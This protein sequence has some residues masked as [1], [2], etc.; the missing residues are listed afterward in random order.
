[1][2]R[3]STGRYRER[4]S[5]LKYAVVIMEGAADDPCEELGNRTPLEA[6]ETP[7]LDSLVAKGRIG[8]VCLVPPDLD[9]DDGVA[10]ASLLGIAP[11]RIAPCG[12]GG[13]EAA[14]AEID[15]GDAAVLRLDLL[16][17]VEDVVADARGGSP[18][19]VE[20]AVLLADLS[21]ALRAAGE[22][23][24]MLVATGEQR[25]VLIDRRGRDFSGTTTTAPTALGETALR[26]ARPAGPHAEALRRVIAVSAEVFAGH[27]VNLLRRELGETPATHAWPWG[28]GRST[29]CA[30]IGAHPPGPRATFVC[31]HALG[32]GLAH[33]AG[34][35]VARTLDA[36]AGPAALAERALAALD[37]QELVATWAR[38]PEAPALEGNA[39]AKVVAIEA[40]DR[41]LV[42]PLVAALR[43]RSG[44]RLLVVAGHRLPVG[45]RRR[46]AG[47]VP[48]LMAGAD[49][50]PPRPGPWN[51]RTA[52]DSDLHVAVGADLLEYFMHGAGGRSA[53]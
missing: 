42:A 33:A 7:A 40:I 21:A 19:G 13:L 51:E 10:L 37:D 31:D 44:W 20:T 8:S 29:A 41:E 30:A 16:T 53:P 34:W 49:I 1:M 2:A 25:G 24:W 15:P 39:V 18:R 50:E 28:A 43:G 11:D 14:G 46:D 22:E 3:G 26:R 52:A 48:F 32:A 6:A 17:V 47:P 36:P 35:N 27:E 38:G 5:A 4:G 23:E 12:S 9:P 45:T